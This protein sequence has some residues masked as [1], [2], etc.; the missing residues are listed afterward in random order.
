MQ[1]GKVWPRG[2]KKAGASE[3]SGGSWRCA[4]AERSKEAKADF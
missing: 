1:D 2:E 4:D 3:F